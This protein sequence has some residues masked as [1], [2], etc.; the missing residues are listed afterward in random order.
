MHPVAPILSLSLLA[1]PI[2]IVAAETP[3]FDPEEVRAHIT[4]LADDL[5]EGRASGAK[6]YRI[7]A[8]YVASRFMAIGAVPMGDPAKGSFYQ[9][10]PLRETALAGNPVLTIIGRDT[11]QRFDSK[12][13]VLIGPN[14]AEAAQ[15][16]SAP[17]V[18]AGY[19]MD[20]PELGLRD[21]DRL[22]VNG[23]VV[24]VL[25]GFP[26][27]LDSSLG[28]HLNSDK[29]RMAMKRGAIGVLTIPTLQESARRN[30]TR[31]AE[32]WGEP[33]SSWLQPNGTPFSRAPG[34]RIDGVLNPNAAAPL[35]AA[36]GRNLPAILKE[37]DRHGG[38][39]R[40]FTF[41]LTARLERSSEFRTYTSPNVIAMIPGSDPAL[42]NEYVLMT[43]HLDHI[44]DH[45]TGQDRINNGAMDNAAGIATM[46]EVAKALARDGRRP[47]RPIL[48]A[49]LTSEE[50]GL[51]GA[52]YLARNPVVP[53]PGR[54]VAVVN[55]DMPIL[56]YRFTDVIAF[57]AESS[58]LG[59]V[60]AR[61]AGAA[62][63]ALSPDPVPAEGLFT[64]SDHYRFVQ[65]GVPSL[66]LVTGY[67]DGGAAAS[68]EFLNKH[69]H[70]PSD[71]LRLPIDWT[72]GA[73][74][75]EVNYHIVRAIADEAEA[76]R[77][78]Q[79]NFFGNEFAAKASKASPPRP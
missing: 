75:A 38:R 3:R 23:K 26:K 8:T 55:F 56:T 57:G 67:A 51:L 49:A 7:A 18:F 64:R 6:G 37:A 16:V 42:A 70:R 33:R 36:A 27:G 72:A 19:G 41:P 43:A 65:Q 5:L 77:W 50:S 66:F 15:V 21:Y 79:G 69:Y 63:I 39:P 32:F 46:L 4:F 61:A 62:G 31:L 40:G 10:V 34:I 30:W 45:G 53:A 17:L 20:R 44:G 13:K 68:E 71:D 11:I 52:D 1:A 24:V 78:Y 35:F 74:F 28:A 73:R 14:A 25:S 29:S 58:T 59:P 22:D 12:D 54:V 2:A 47:R 60:V 9:E 76:P 48:F